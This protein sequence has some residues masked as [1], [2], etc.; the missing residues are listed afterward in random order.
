VQVRPEAQI[1]PPV[2]P[3]PPHW[4]HFATV[5]LPPVVVLVVV[6]S[7]LEVGDEEPPP[8]EDPSPTVMLEEPLL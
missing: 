4:P 3:C 8:L 1:V 5:P 7:A 6:D 2:H